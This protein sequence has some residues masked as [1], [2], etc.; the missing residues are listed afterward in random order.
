VSLTLRNGAEA[1]M[2]KNLTLPLMM[3]VAVTGCAG[4]VVPIT[5][6]P[7]LRL[8]GL[9]FSDCALAS[10]GVARP[11][12]KRSAKP[13]TENAKADDFGCDMINP[14][15]YSPQNERL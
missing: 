14:P 7:K 1:V 12:A 11:I 9:R 5:T 8:V 4:L 2:L 10:A 6:L 13:R 15:E 3:L